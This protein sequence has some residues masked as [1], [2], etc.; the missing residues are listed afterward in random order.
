MEKVAEE[1]LKAKELRESWN[2]FLDKKYY[3]LSI[4]QKEYDFIK[5]M[6]GPLSERINLNNKLLSLKKKIAVLEEKK[7]KD[8]LELETLKGKELKKEIILAIKEARRKKGFSLIFPEE[9]F[10]LFYDEKVDFNTFLLEEL[11]AREE[12]RLKQ[13]T[14]D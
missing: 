14:N 11:T 10:I 6:N 8:F 1:Y 3:Q 13:N 5:N 12:E 4:Y 2:L 9:D 7:R